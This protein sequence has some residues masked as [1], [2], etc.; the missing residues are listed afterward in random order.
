MP[1]SKKYLMNLRQAQSFVGKKLES[2]ERDKHAV[3]I[4]FTDGSAIGIE[5]I[6]PSTFTGNNVYYYEPAKKDD[7]G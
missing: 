3:I 5:P 7:E 1:E 4:R 6:Q 2:I